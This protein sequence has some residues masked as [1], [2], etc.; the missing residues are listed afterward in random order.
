MTSSPPAMAVVGITDA[1]AASLTPAIADIVGRAEI[2]VGGARHLAFFPDH[3]ARRI[4]IRSDMATLVETL[5]AEQAAGRRIVVLASGDPLLYGIGSTL[6]RFFPAD[7]LHIYPNVSAVQLAW[8]RVVEPWHD[9]GI[10]SVHGRMLAPMIGAARQHMRL[11]V[12]T[13]GDHTPAAIATALLA[14]GL[15]DRPAAVCERLGGP[16]ERVTRTT[17]AALPE[18]TFDPLNVLLLLPANEGAIPANAPRGWLPGAPDDAFAQR[19]PERGLITKREVRVL[20][21]AALGLRAEDVLWD[22]GAGSGSVA[23]EAARHVP[24]ARV[25]AIE[26]DPV[27]LALIAE[28][29]RRFGTANVSIIAGNAPEACADLPDPDAVFIGGSGGA[30]AAI[31]ATA[32]A[33]FHVGGRLVINLATLEGLHEAFAAIQAHGE[34][35]EV[36][37]ISIARGKAIGANT[38]LQAL[39][40]VFIISAERRS[41]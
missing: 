5:R 36:T 20:S 19:A 21:L 1:G 16:E 30:L 38:R 34:T 39:N 7:A 11:A 22:I 26:R 29:C 3:P 27:S 40:P 33:R 32:M 2:L 18:Q 17:L 37:Q 14:A 13:D 9:A 10:V 24:S 35:S 15:P 28:N 8:A 12:L 41:G 25:Y 6:R 4:A 31:I 23:I